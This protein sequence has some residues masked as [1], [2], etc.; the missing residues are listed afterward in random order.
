MHNRHEG[1]HTLYTQT[2][3]AGVQNSTAPLLVL[4]HGWGM[5]SDIWQTLIPELQ[6]Q[7]SITVIDLP[8]LGRSAACLPTVYELETVVQQLAEVAPPTAIWLGWSLGG[9][10]AMAF[11]QR[12]PERVSQLITLGSSPCFMMRKDWS[13]GMEEAAY[14]QFEVELLANPA[15][16]LKRFNQLQVRG[17]AT[18]RVDLKVLTRIV[19]EVQP[20]LGGLSASLALLRQDYRELYRATCLPT[21][22][23]LCELDTLAPAAMAN[24]LSILQPQAN[25][26]VLLEQSHVG[27]LSAPQGVADK[28]R[29][30]SL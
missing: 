17:S 5:H 24:T 22:H 20:S 25:V 14:G 13:F 11:A 7:Y 10:I 6:Q 23:L 2:Y 16:T 3:A 21:L 12:Y 1:S 8:G 4:L 19:A 26:A 15:K 18:A 9:I 30:F 29:M 28:V 27:F